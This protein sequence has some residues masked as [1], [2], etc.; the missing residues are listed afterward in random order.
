[1]FFHEGID[2]GLVNRVIGLFGDDLALLVVNYQTVALEA[3]VFV[4][5]GVCLGG[6]I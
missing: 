1:M 2:L 6:G 3:Q 5:L 4:D